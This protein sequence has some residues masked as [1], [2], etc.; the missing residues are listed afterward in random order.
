[1]E[2]GVKIGEH[3]GVVRV[4]RRVFQRLLPEGPNAERCARR[5]ISSAPGLRASPN[6]SCAGVN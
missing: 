5:T 1:V 2:F 6:V 4:R 3:R